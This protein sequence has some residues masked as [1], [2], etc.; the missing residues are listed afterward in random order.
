M[1]DAYPWYS[2][3]PFSLSLS[4]SLLLPQPNWP[5]VRGYGRLFL[6]R[7]VG[8]DGRRE[9]VVVADREL[10]GQDVLCLHGLL[11]YRW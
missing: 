11:Y 7:R 3:P 10:H 6:R 4:A 5:R 8:E 9:D 2:S 1:H